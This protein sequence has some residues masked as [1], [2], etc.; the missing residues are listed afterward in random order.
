MDIHLKKCGV[1]AMDMKTGQRVAT[2]SIT[3]R[4]EPFPVIR[5]NQSHKHLGLR[6]AINGN[7]SDEKHNVCTEMKKRLA[8][9]AEDTVLSRIEKEIV[10]KTAVCSVFRYIAG[11]VDWTRTVLDDISKLWVRAY[12]QAWTLSASTDSSPMMLSVEDGGGGCPPAVDL[13]THEVYEVLEQ[14]VGLPGEISQ[15]TTHPSAMHCAWLF[16]TRPSRP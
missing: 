9:L 8:A 6:M 5:P 7:F 14:W 1:T 4:S 2:D 12:K 16:S 15:I 10:I 3:L 11:F 13:W